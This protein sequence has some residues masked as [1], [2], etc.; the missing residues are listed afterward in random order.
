MMIMM[1]NNMFYSKRILFVFPFL[2]WLMTKIHHSPSG[3]SWWRGFTVDWQPRWYIG[4]YAFQC[5]SLDSQL[6]RHFGCTCLSESEHESLRSILKSSLREFHLTISSSFDSGSSEWGKN[7]WHGK[8]IEKRRSREGPLECPVSDAAWQPQMLW[9]TNWRIQVWSSEW[10]NQTSFDLVRVCFT[11][12]WFLHG[13]LI[14]FSRLKQV[15][16]T[17]ASSCNVARAPKKH[18]FISPSNLDDSSVPGHKSSSLIPETSQKSPLGEHSP[19]LSKVPN[20]W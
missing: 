5:S 14:R 11:T 17:E 7:P 18:P 2:C 3:H 13:G 9:K 12:E 10:P 1:I 16:H 19:T 15:L 20:A 4:S 6:T 8:Y